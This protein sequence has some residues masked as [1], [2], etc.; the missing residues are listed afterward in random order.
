MSSIRVPHATCSR[1][2]VAVTGTSP[3][4]V[5]RCTSTSPGAV[6]AA[7]GGG[8]D[9]SP[10]CVSTTGT[11]TTA[12]TT[13]AAAAPSPQRRTTPPVLHL[14]HQ[15]GQQGGGQ[16][17]VG[18]GVL[19]HGG[20][21]PAEQPGQPGELADGARALG[22]ARQVTLER[23]AVGRRQRAEHVGRVVVGEGTAHPATP[24]SSSAS[25]SARSA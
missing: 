1:P 9:P 2:R 24:S 15:G 16:R 3:T 25:L 18:H 5:I 23:Q 7:E 17:R 10:T 14:A 12:T 22:A 20:V 4:G 19:E 13:A 6:L 21:D 11:L 8:P